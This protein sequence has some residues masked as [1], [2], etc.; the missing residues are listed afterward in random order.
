MRNHEIKDAL[1]EANLKQWQLAELLQ[2]SEF[3]LSRKLR[4]ELP[5][6]DKKE[7]LEVIQKER[8]VTCGK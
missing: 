3:T 4:N 2:I 7:I 1:K 5:E 6:A 8:G